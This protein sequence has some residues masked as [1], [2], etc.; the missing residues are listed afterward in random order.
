MA[1]SHPYLTDATVSD[2]EAVV[3]RLLGVQAENQSQAMWAVATRTT[4]PDLGRL[5]GLLHDGRIVRTHVLRPTWHFVRADDLGWLGDLCRPRLQVLVERQLMQ[6]GVDHL[7]GSRAIA[8]IAGAVAGCARTRRELMADL[9]ESGLAFDGQQLMLLAAA[10]E[11]DEVICSGPL[12]DGTHTYASFRDRVPSTRRLDR[13]AA[14]AESR[15][16]EWC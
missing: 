7:T 10:A 6:L 14:L 1:P 4:E 3:D 2:P 13:D 15:R 8:V 11:I 9:A 16:R 12:R 5:S